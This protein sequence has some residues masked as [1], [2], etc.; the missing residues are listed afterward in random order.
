M[1]N[2]TTLL[3]LFIFVSCSAPSQEKIA[4]KETPSSKATEE[5]PQQKKPENKKDT[6]IEKQK[7]LPEKKEPNVTSK[8]KVYEF[9][10]HI[11]CSICQTMA[12]K[13]SAVDIQLYGNCGKQS[14]GLKV[15]I[16]YPTETDTRIEEWVLLKKVDNIYTYKSDFEGKLWEFT[17]IGECKASLRCLNDAKISTI[18]LAEADDEPIKDKQKE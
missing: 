14:Y 18:Y 12:G 2:I 9:F 4:I 10:N 13:N 1:K 16:K 7:I 17:L 5:K 6:V 3:F 15:E 11:G 8:E